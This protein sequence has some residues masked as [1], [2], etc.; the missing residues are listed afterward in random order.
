M[1]QRPVNRAGMLGPSGLSFL[2]RRLGSL[3]SNFAMSSV[4]KWLVHRA[5]AA[6]Q[7]KSGFA[8]QVI[9]VAIGVHQLDGSFRSFHAIRT[10]RPYRNFYRSHEASVMHLGV[11]REDISFRPPSSSGGKPVVSGQS[12][13]AYLICKSFRCRVTAVTSSLKFL[14]ITLVKLADGVSMSTVQSYR[15]LIV[16][17]K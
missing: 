4:T 13:R 14:A 12:I 9:L 2:D 15:D 11:R 3:K 7:G 10:V 17:R 8:G 6:A 1:S 5:A 16:W